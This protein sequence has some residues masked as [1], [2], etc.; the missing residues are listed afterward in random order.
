MI[1]VIDGRYLYTRTKRLTVSKPEFTVICWDARIPGEIEP[2]D[3]N[4]VPIERLPVYHLFRPLNAFGGV[5]FAPHRRL[6][7]GKR[8][9][10][11]LA[12]HFALETMHVEIGLSASKTAILSANFHKREASCVPVSDL[13]AMARRL[14]RGVADIKRR[15][16]SP[17]PT[18]SQPCY[19]HEERKGV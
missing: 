10:A 14:I 19:Q 2:V 15:Y 18:R 9:A 8:C 16:H 3:F 4:V 1:E 17:N 13:V 12:C 11:S 6:S 5:I 7:G